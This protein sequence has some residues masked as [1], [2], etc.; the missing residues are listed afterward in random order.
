MCEIRRVNDTDYRIT[1]NNQTRFIQTKNEYQFD[2]RINGIKS[3][4]LEGIGM[5]FL[6]KNKK[7][8][9]LSQAASKR[10]LKEKFRKQQIF[11]GNNNPYLLLSKEEKDNIMQ[12]VKKSIIKEEKKNKMLCTA[13]MGFK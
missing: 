5:A 8:I 11:S 1:A 2:P 10:L 6:V 9:V 12:A 13:A 3:L 4:N 7:E